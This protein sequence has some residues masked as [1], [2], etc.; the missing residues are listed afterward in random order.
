MRHGLVS[1]TI[2]QITVTSQ[3]SI[4]PHTYIITNKVVVYLSVSKIDFNESLI[5]I[6]F[7]LSKVIFFLTILLVPC[8]VVVSA[9]LAIVTISEV[10][11][12]RRVVYASPPVQ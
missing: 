4:T 5:A 1:V 9:Y 3:C 11:R 12:N 10:L 6:Y 2:E 7:I 8:I